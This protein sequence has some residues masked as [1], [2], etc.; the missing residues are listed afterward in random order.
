[1]M[2]ALLVKSVWTLLMLVAL[3]EFQR[4][5]VR[6]RSS[7]AITNVLWAVSAGIG[8]GVVLHNIYVAWTVMT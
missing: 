6:D 8:A 5:E 3:V 7:T 2:P 4:A 1:M